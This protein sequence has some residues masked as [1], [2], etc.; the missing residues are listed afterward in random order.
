MMFVLP[1]IQSSQILQIN[2]SNV[3]ILSILTLLIQLPNA[4][5]VYHPVLIVQVYG[6]VH[7]VSH[8]NSLFPI[9][10]A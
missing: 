6:D 1:T 8:L 3:L 7:H 2:V 10:N 4:P 9:A 5:T